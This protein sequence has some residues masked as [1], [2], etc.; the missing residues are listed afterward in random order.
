MYPT[1]REET[2][3][4]P[5]LRHVFASSELVDLR[6]RHYREFHRVSRADPRY[7]QLRALVGVAAVPHLKIIMSVGG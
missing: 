7:A 2:V 3:E 4:Y 5:E 6:V 1:A